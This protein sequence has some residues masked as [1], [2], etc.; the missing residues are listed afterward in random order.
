M[1]GKHHR[2]GASARLGVAPL[3]RLGS[4]HVDRRA[5]PRHS[6]PTRPAREGKPVYQGEKRAMVLKVH[7]PRQSWARTAPVVSGQPLQHLEGR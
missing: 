1:A 4:A 7:G 2:P 3:A 6:A 5:G